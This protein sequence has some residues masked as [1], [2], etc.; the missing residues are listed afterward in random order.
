MSSDDEYTSGCDEEEQH[1]RHNT[2]DIIRWLI[3]AGFTKGQAE[4]IATQ[5]IE[6]WD[7]LSRFHLMFYGN[8]IPQGI[9]PGQRAAMNHFL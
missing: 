3:L 7:V 1:F 5:L 8:T 4:D 2:D 9:L 6:G